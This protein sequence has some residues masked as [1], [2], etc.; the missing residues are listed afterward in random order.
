VAALNTGK[1]L[2]VHLSYSPVANLWLASSRNGCKILS[3]S[4]EENTITELCEWVTEESGKEPE[5]N[6]ARYSPDASMIVTG[7][8]DG[9]VLVWKAQKPPA[10]P[11]LHRKCGTKGKE[12]LDADFSPDGKYV[13]ACDGA[14]TCRV[15]ELA[16]EEPE[17][18]TVITYASPAVKGKVFIKLCRF[19]SDASGKTTL[20]L[21]ANGGRGPA[22]VGLF[23]IDGTK[24]KEVNMDK[25]PIKSIAVDPN[26]GRFVVGLMS[27]AKSVYTC[28]GLS[29]IKKTKELHSLPAQAV[30]FLGE[31]TAVSGSGDRDLHLLNFKGG[32]GSVLCYL[33]V[34][35]LA[36]MAVAAMVLRI[37]VKGAS[38]GQGRLE[39]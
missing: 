15:W 2:V 27:G 11:V 9:Q 23:S 30:A 10:V 16:K 39:M 37:G 24:L 33:F 5:Q 8:T 34:L 19:W 22:L 28:P 26:N 17:D 29:C 31:G 6:L 13:A 38:L 1:S 14:G 12:I 18:G 36:L 7:G 25:Q 32:S 20:I 35:L 21:G 3:L 4:V